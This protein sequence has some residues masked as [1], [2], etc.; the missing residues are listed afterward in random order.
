[1]Q[2]VKKFILFIS[3]FIAGKANA[4]FYTL[5]YPPFS[6]L[7]EQAPKGIAIHFIKEIFKLTNIKEDVVISNWENALEK[8]KK[9]EIDGIFPAIKTKNRE[10]FLIFP[11]ESIFSEEIIFIGNKDDVEK[12]ETNI[13]E[14][15]GKKI[16][17]GKGFSL[18]KHIDELTLNHK[19]IR[20]DE[21]K[22][23]NCVNKVLNK[24]VD[25]FI[26]DKLIAA[27]ALM[28][29]GKKAESLFTS[30]K[31]LES[32]PNYLAIAKKS[33]YINKIKEIENTI[34]KLKKENFIKKIMTEDFKDCL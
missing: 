27:I 12:T 7:N 11:N 2:K 25:F 10:E 14:L 15:N 9:Q 16:C 3:L 23:F 8:A 21:E 1:M 17:S 18:G 22:V 4:V 20:E 24:E 19:I 31:I 5:E 33:K 30:K 13:S 28:H 29:A 26:A 32:T 6:C 34:A